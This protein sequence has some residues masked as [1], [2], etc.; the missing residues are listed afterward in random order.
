MM[1]IFKEEAIDI[2]RNLPDHAT[3][4]DLMYEFY[5]ENHFK[6]SKHWKGYFF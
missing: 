4:N 6:G 2:I 5:G 1:N 3:W